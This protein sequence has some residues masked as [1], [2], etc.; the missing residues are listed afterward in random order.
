MECSDVDLKEIAD[1]LG[2]NWKTMAKALGLDK[3]GISKIEESGNTNVFA[4]IISHWKRHNTDTPL[5]FIAL[6]TKLCESAE[7]RERQDYLTEIMHQILGN[8]VK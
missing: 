3:N 7:Y 6:L 5:S 1:K 2:K 4:G 8:T